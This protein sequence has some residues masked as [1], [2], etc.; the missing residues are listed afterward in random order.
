ME[1]ITNEPNPVHTTRAGHTPRALNTP[2][3]MCIH[4]TTAAHLCVAATGHR[5]CCHS[6][7]AVHIPASTWGLLM[8]NAGFGAVRSAVDVATRLS[9]RARGYHAAAVTIPTSRAHAVP[10]RLCGLKRQQKRNINQQNGAGCVLFWIRDVLCTPQLRCIILDSRHALHP[11]PR[12]FGALGYHA[13]AVTPHVRCVCA[14]HISNRGLWHH[15][16]KVERC[17][18]VCVTSW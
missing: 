3:A 4:H 11:A 7:S 10:L 12:T 1:Q 13:A 8:D 2:A 5:R 16:V 6:D 17:W 18:N 14:K 15:G 9:Y